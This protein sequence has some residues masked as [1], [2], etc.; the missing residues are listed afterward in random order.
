MTHQ[1]TP[2]LLLTTEHSASS[3]GIPVLVR[4]K[5][6]LTGEGEGYS[7]H[8]PADVFEYGGQRW[9]AAKHVERYAKHHADNAELQAAAAAFCRTE[10]AA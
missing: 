1:L 7:V 3:Q 2:S 10:V 8:G 4:D 5:S 9:P 6:Q